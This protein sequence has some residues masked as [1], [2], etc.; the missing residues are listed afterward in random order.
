VL[1]RR[2]RNPKALD[3]GAAIGAL[4]LAISF[5][6]D[7][8]VNNAALIVVVPWVEIGAALVIVASADERTL[9]HRVLGCRPLASLGLISY[10]VYLWHYPIARALREDMPWTETLPIVVGVSFAV[11]TASYFLIER[12]LREYRRRFATAKVL[13]V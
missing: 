3:A 13:T 8:L 5:Q 7:G 1:P 9:C 10:A 12:P 2:T 11:A 6:I 4:L